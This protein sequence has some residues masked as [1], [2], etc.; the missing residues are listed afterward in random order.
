MVAV[1]LHPVPVI[2]CKVIIKFITENLEKFKGI[3]KRI[4]FYENIDGENITVS[5]KTCHFPFFGIY[6]HDVN[7]DD[8]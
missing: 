6:E 4:F 1:T 3:M 5:S 2:V 7:Y 8:F